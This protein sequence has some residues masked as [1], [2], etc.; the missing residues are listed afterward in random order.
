M[1]AATLPLFLD[2]NMPDSIGRYLQQRGHS[3]LRQRF[4]IPADSPDQLVATTAMKAGRILVTQ[5]KD[6]NSQRF[7]QERFAELSRILV[8]GQSEA[9]LAALQ[10]HMHLIEFQWEHCRQIGSV[11]MVAHVK[12]G[13]IRFRA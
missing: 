11:R 12:V 1:V 10:E 7:H 3:V 8:N 4:Y 9:L 5:D 2:N 13:Q 6:F